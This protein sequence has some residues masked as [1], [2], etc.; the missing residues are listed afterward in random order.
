MNHTALG[1]CSSSPIVP[2]ASALAPGFSHPASVTM[3][4]WLF[5]PCLPHTVLLQ[6]HPHLPVSPFPSSDYATCHFG[7]LLPSLSAI[8]VKKP[9]DSDSTPHF[10]PLILVAAHNHSGTSWSRMPRTSMLCGSWR[11]LP[12]PS[13]E[14][15][16]HL[17]PS[18]PG[19]PLLHRALLLNA[20]HWF[21]R[22]VELEP[23][24]SSF[25]IARSSS[26]LPRTP[27]TLDVS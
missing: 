1:T 20:L 27:R 22:L 14:L 11:R 10:F 19:S 9:P 8:Q 6:Q 15:C 24:R 23:L 17:N 13:P 25:L 5:F 12:F 26:A 18:S 7:H 4:N 2:K 21:Y 16:D 3:A